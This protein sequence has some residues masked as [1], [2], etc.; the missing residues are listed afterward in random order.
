MARTVLRFGITPDVDTLTPSLEHVEERIVNIPVLYQALWTAFRRIEERRFDREGPGWERLADSTV[1]ERERLGIG[2]EHP[3]LNRTGAPGGGTLRRSLTTKGAKY[4][5]IE[6][7]PD[8]VFFGTRDPLARYHQD[9]THG[10]GRDH[11]VSMPARPLVDLTEADA[12]VF[13]GIIAEWIYG[14][15]V[16]ETFSAAS[17]AI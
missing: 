2:G 16:E 11:N 3:I 12:D 6:P 10:A 13:T 4:S 9:G 1:A 17:G 7:L 5:Y 14:D 8:G 15:V